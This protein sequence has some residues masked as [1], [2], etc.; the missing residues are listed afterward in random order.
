M[1]RTKEGKERRRRKIYSTTVQELD[2]LLRTVHK[3]DC[4]VVMGDLN[5]DLQRNAEHCTGQWF[6][7]IKDNGYGEEI[8]NV[9]RS[10]DLFT[11]NTLFKPAR[12]TWGH[13]KK[14]R[15]Y[16]ERNVERER[17]RNTEREM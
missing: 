1:F 4:I 16:N 15:Y 2:A 9:M 8:L 10:H 14:L 7:Q 11:V 3:T 12:K 6:M 17:E 5:C 13:K